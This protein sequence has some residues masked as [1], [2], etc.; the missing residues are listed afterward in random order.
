[1][2]D[3]LG[4][5]RGVAEEIR[6]AADRWFARRIALHALNAIKDDIDENGRW[7]R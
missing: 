1:V 6:V 3:A 4:G 5:G 7:R 2:C